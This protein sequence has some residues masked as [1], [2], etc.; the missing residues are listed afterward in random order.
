MD[1][2][3]SKRDREFMAAIGYC[4]TAWGSIDDMLFAI[5]WACLG[6]TRERASIVYFRITSISARCDLTNELLRTFLPVESDLE[7]QS[8]TTHWSQIVAR[9]KELII[10]RNR[11]AHQPVTTRIKYAVAGEMV[12]G[13]SLW[14]TWPE[15]H[16]SDYERASQLKK[17]ALKYQDLEDHLNAVGKLSSDLLAFR[18]GPLLKYTPER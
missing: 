7:G 12:A 13:D 10:V 9:L 3:L 2:A 8:D 18:C 6:C 1:D 4:V 16:V 17:P 15:S 14:E 5:C 11:L